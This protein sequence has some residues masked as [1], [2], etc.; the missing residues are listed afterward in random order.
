MMRGLLRMTLFCIGGLLLLLT[1]ALSLARRDSATTT[2]WLIVQQFQPDGTARLALLS[3][4]GGRLRYITPPA[5]NYRVERS[6]DEGLY[7]RAQQRTGESQLLYLRSDDW[8]A[9]VVVRELGTSPIYWAPDGKSLI[10][11]DF[12][13][14][15]LKRVDVASALT[16][17]TFFQTTL[18]TNPAVFD[19]LVVFSPDWAYLPVQYPPTDQTDVYRVRLDGTAAVNLTPHIPHPALP[20]A[21]LSGTDWL[22]IQ[23]ANPAQSPSRYL[24]RLHPDGS[25]LAP[26][27]IMD[28]PAQLEIVE[29]LP[30]EN[31]VI[32]SGGPNGPLVAV[33]PE[34]PIPIWQ[35]NSEVDYVHPAGAGRL[36]LLDD[37]VLDLVDVTDGTRRQLYTPS[38]AYHYLDA[39][40]Q[41]DEWFYFY[42]YSLVANPIN[43]RRLP[44]PEGNLNRVNLATGRVELLVSNVSNFVGGHLAPDDASLIV[45]AQINGQSG[46]FRL[47]TDG[48][49]YQRL[50]RDSFHTT[51]GGFGPPIEH[52]WSALPL[53]LIGPAL[54]LLALLPYRKITRRA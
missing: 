53:L 30:A 9:Q 21:W 26:L 16:H 31:L 35:F 38:A 19:H 46:L 40:A 27:V 13:G 17:T 20:V 1:A 49:G 5:A 48:S 50:T 12:L 22:I 42:E 39:V 25:K 47:N 29:W 2:H 4:I 45:Q 36:V 33:H 14:G 32:L 52:K 24:W 7:L 18:P 54:L 41:S 44:M 37:P 11:L 15:L 6:S 43:P 34:R 8:Q 3:P 10:Y 23:I 51:F 28:D